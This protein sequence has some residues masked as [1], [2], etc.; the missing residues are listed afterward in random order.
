[1]T[2]KD[3]LEYIVSELESIRVPVSELDGIGQPIVRSIKNLKGCL[4]AIKEAEENV[5]QDQED[6]ADERDADPE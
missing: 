3:V 1:M 2:I 4:D 5:K 6:E